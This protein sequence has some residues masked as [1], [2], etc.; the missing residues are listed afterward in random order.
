M[1]V[2]LKITT[3]TVVYKTGVEISF[4]E[5]FFGGVRVT[6]NKEL[7]IRNIFFEVFFVPLIER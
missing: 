7:T 6:T 4:L 3:V 2:D 5:R 1:P